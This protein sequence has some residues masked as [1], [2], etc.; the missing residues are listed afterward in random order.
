L[1]RA[2]AEPVGRERRTWAEYEKKKEA[3]EAA[4]KA[5]APKAES[6]TA[7]PKKSHEIP[8]LPTMEDAAETVL[9]D[10]I[11]VAARIARDASR[12][13]PVAD[14]LLPAVRDAVDWLTEH[15]NPI[16][17]VK[18]IRV[19]TQVQE[20]PMIEA[21][22]RPLKSRVTWLRNQALILMSLTGADLPTEIGEDVAEGEL[23]PRIPSYLKALRNT[24]QPGVPYC[25][26]V[27]ILCGLS[28]WIVNLATA[29]GLY[30]LA[31]RL[32]GSKGIV[33]RHPFAVLKLVARFRDQMDWLAPPEHFDVPN[34]AQTVAHTMLREG[35]LL[36]G[37][38][39]VLLAALF[40][41]RK[42]ANWFG[43]STLVA[44]SLTLFIPFWLVGAGARNWSRFS[45]RNAADK[46]DCASLALP[47]RIFN[48]P[49][50]LPEIMRAIS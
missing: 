35:W 34:W 20:P 33:L 11:E 32:L 44:A 12:R 8:A 14:K 6:K 47:F 46:V 18:M 22:R 17:Q 16:T 45:A 31:L 19:V 2:I 36:T 26:F 7:E 40:A 24:R 1:S 3:L 41:A 39:I 10:R 30:A 9:A 13:P 21:A 5:E 15:G 38:A 4:K 23:L 25:F 29:I 27:G 48:H 37:I 50:R 42:S 49:T 43:P 28:E